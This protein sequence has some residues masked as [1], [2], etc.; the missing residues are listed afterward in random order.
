MKAM[1]RTTGTLVGL[2][3][4]AAAGPAEGLGL[5]Q[6][7]LASLTRR[8][9]TMDDGLP[10]N[11]VQ[12]IQRTRDG[13]L[14]LGTEEGLARFDGWR[15]TL[16][17][18]GNVA[19]RHDSNVVAL[20][21]TPDG[22]LWIGTRWG[23]LVRRAGA[24]FEAVALPSRHVTALHAG[25]NGRLWV[26]TRDA[27][28]FRQHRDGFAAVEGLPAGSHVTS[29]AETPDGVLWLGTYGHGLFSVRAP[30]STAERIRRAE[31]G[32]VTA[33]LADRSGRLWVGLW[34][35]GVC[36]LEAE[37]PKCARTYTAPRELGSNMVSAL[38]EDSA[39]RMWVGSKP[40]GLTVLEPPGTQ[41]RTRT[42]QTS[43][44]SVREGLSAETVSS[45]AESPPGMI[46][47][48][49]LGGG[50]DLFHPGYV[51]AVTT[52]QGL[53]DG[54][55]LG[56]CEGRDGS[57]WMGSAGGH[58]SRLKGRV[59]VRVLGREGER[60]PVSSVWPRPDGGVWAGTLGAGLFA[61]DARGQVIGHLT[62]AQGLPSDHVLALAEGTRGS[63]WIGLGQKAGLVVAGAGLDLRERH[64]EG[65]TV[66]ALAFGK[67]GSAYAGTWSHGLAVLREGRWKRYDP[68]NGLG[69]ETVHSLHLDGDGRLWI[70]TLGGGLNLLDGRGLRRWGTR[71]GLFSD[72]LGDILED[73]RGRL[74]I[75]TNRG[76]F[77]VRKDELLRGGRVVS[78][79]YGREDGMPATECSFGAQPS[80]WRLRDARLAFSTVSGVAIVDPAR[81]PHDS[82]PLRLHV[83]R[84]ESGG[85]ELSPE[86]GAALSPGESLSVGY[87]AIAFADA[88][89]VVFRH[90]LEGA[91][92]DW[93]E[94]GRR[95]EAHY[96]HI[97]PGDHT[98]RVQAR[99]LWSS[100]WVAE[101]SVP[102]R[103]E[104]AFH[105]TAVFR[106][107][108]GLAVALAAFGAHRVA[109][110]RLRARSAQLAE[111]NRFAQDIHDNLSQVMTGLALQL[112]AVREN[113]PGRPEAARSYLDRAEQLA[114]MAIEQARRTIR[115][116]HAPQGRGPS[117]AR[118]LRDSIQPLVDGT[119]VHVATKELGDPFP[120]PP[121][122]EDE[123]FHI[124]QEAVSNAL[125]H[126]GARKIEITVR[127]EGGGVHVQ[128]ADDGR[129]F[130]PASADAA[131][132]PGLGLSG[133][134]RRVEEQRGTL[135]IESRPGGGTTVDVF[136]PCPK[137]LFGRR[138]P[139]EPNTPG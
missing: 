93:V 46:W 19:A 105:Q 77:Y 11:S 20:A 29:F 70:G 116:L 90:R 136:V 32:A 137:P 27:G 97:P 107:A 30:S 38:L 57:L 111:R 80:S 130:E 28:A 117:L 92:Q 50:L 36:V 98:L 65:S 52:R 56:L 64:L 16:F 129:G 18:P 82:P 104:A 132:S 68:S 88:A 49:T 31:D 126:G 58:L 22:A 102:V 33:L 59:S 121:E 8:A 119:P 43:R 17:D 39:G 67:D 63:L 115:G 42:S 87:A 72:K 34:G 86:A 6:N 74:W 25:R 55:V 89:R 15:F 41:S 134:W 44:F 101:A 125:R 114:Q 124:G 108:C 14:W 79:P 45:L 109:V 37:G 2:L 110:R 10:Q 1:R 48:G 112:D 127:Y 139:A 13:Y 122:I 9:W 123:M 21:E 35:G 71:E 118:A 106:F 69:S 85:R 73:D 131:R 103:M 60:A 138:S 54:L 40:G 100:D 135:R 62:R 128:V 113:L 66:I 76:L 78:V 3:A 84:L 51:S 4:A 95:R 96:T 99:Y 81:V 23:G 47:V 5:P 7:R 133:M 26:G 120:L 61:L 24:R 75:S 53:P 83:D 94:A 91:Q 12:A